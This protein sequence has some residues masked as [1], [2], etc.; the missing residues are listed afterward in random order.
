[1]GAPTTYCS[2]LQNDT[3]QMVPYDASA[4]I[5]LVFASA[6]GLPLAGITVAQPVQVMSGS[7]V[8]IHYI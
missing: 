8:T 1:M 6:A 2:R 7:R 4:R 5:P 3:V